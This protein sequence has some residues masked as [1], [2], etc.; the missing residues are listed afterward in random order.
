MVMET[1]IPISSMNDTFNPITR[2]FSAGYELVENAEVHKYNEDEAIMDYQ[3]FDNLS[4]R[5][6]KHFV[7][8]IGGLHYQ[9]KRNQSLPSGAVAVPADNHSDPKTLLIQR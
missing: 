2:P 7:G 4:R 6:G 5:F 3:M 1:T 8:Y 9:F